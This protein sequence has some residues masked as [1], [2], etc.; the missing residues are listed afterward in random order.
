MSNMNFAARSN[1][2]KIKDLEGLKKSLKPF[3]HL[4]I[5]EQQNERYCILANNYD[6]FF[7]TATITVNEEFEETAEIELDPQIHIIPY[8]EDKEILIV[9]EVA[10]DKLRYIYGTSYAY[11]KDRGRICVDLDHIHRLIEERWS[12]DEYDSF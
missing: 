10:N 8:L 3:E 6:S 12:T 11:M 2:V 4:L 5:E 9:M 1:C 7:Q